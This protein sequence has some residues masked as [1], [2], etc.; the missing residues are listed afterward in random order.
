MLSPEDFFPLYAEL[1][2]GLAGF[3]GIVSAFAG[4][5]RQFRPTELARVISVVAASSCVLVGCF[6]IFSVLAWGANVSTSYQVA[7]AAC[8]AVSAAYFFSAFPRA[9]RSSKDPDSTSESWALLVT[10]G[11]YLAIMLIY[12]GA[13]LTTMGFFCLIMGFSV[14]LLHGL[15]MFV[16]VLTRAN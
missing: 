1:S 5:D 13:V 12:A 11:A 14:H 9:W 16:R 7:G 10:A 3:A 6:A 4:R 2:L 8:L 15:W